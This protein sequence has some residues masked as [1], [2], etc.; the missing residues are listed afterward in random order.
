MRNIN[1]YSA[2]WRHLAVLAVVAVLCIAFAVPA[3]AADPP[4]LVRAAT[5]GDGTAIILIFDKA[6]ANPD[7]KHGQF[8]ASTV[9]EAVYFSGAALDTNDKRI[10]LTIDGGPI[11][12]GDSV[13]VSYTEGD[14]IAVDTGALETFEDRP[15]VNAVFS[16]GSGEPGDPFIIT[17]RTSWMRQGII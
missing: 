1:I 10:I 17:V 9:T 12:Y 16:D 14:V 3:L 2:R 13:T 5:N 15:V 6:M 7:G 11:E 8:T 4:V